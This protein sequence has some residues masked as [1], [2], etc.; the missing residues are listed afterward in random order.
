MDTEYKEQVVER[1]IRENKHGDRKSERCNKV[2]SHKVGDLH[3]YAM[4]TKVAKE[5]NRAPLSD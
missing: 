4:A 1:H 2:E 5:Y 3:L